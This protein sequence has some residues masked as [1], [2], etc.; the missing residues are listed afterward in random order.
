[1]CTYPKMAPWVLTHSHIV[2]NGLSA[3]LSLL[4]NW[5]FVSRGLEQVEV[6]GTLFTVET[7]GTSNGRPV[8]LT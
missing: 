3:N 4:E 8:L 6:K 1:M 5:F 2:S 7:Q